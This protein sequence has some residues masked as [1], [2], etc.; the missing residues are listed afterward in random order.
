MFQKKRT[1]M[2]FLIL[3]ILVL[4]AGGIYLYQ[5]FYTLKEADL[6]LFMGQSNMSGAGGSA[7]EAP[8][9]IKGAAYEYRAITQPEELVVLEE[10]FGELEHKEGYLDDR[11]LIE[12]GGSLVTAFVNAY[13][14]ETKE[15]VVAVSASRGS[16]QISSF[17]NYL[18]EDVIERLENAKQTMMEQQV[19]I[20]HIYMVWFQ[21]ET[22]AYL[23][24][25]K[26]QYIGGMQKLLNTL[27]PYGVERC[28][29][30][31][32]GN[33][34]MEGKKVDTRGMHEIQETL[35]ETDENF[36]LV[37]T[38]PKELSEPPYMEDGIHFTQKGLNAIGE[39]AGKQ[40]G[41]Y[42]KSVTEGR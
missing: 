8:E 9:L 33:V 37:S 40:A 38:L 16:A 22:D 23:E 32:I 7:E 35:C 21:G 17:N 27:Q 2:I 30:I 15:R 6:I 42:V 18:V 29:V 11:G 41:S 4:V 34:M 24:T 5:D 10:P 19:N 1:R 39:D 3:S 31:Q 12:R 20:R 13:Y 36:V 25:P 26:E 14:K 28:F